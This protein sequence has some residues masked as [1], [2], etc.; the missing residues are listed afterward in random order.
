MEVTG[1]LMNMLCMHVLNTLLDKKLNRANNLHF[2]SQF[3]S[4]LTRVLSEMDIILRFVNT[5][6]F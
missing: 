3:K 5:M 1:L 2:C 6:D 4:I